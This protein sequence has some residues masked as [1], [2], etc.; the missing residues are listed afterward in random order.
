MLSEHQCSLIESGLTTNVEP[1]KV[2]AYLCLHM[3]LMLGEV[4]ALR[5]QDV[6][7]ES[8]SVNVVNTIGR[9]DGD[10]GKES[11]FTSAAYPRLLPM[12]PHVYRYLVKHSDLYTSD[13]C[14]IMNGST[15]VPFFHQMQNLLTSISTKYAVGETVSAM[16]LRNAFIRRCIRSNVDLFSICA[17]IGVKQPNVIVR[18]FD[19]Y[20]TPNLKSVSAIE[21]YV[22]ASGQIE[23]DDTDLINEPKRMNLLIL[24]AGSQGPVVK[25]IA[26][27]L[28]VFNEIAFLDDNPYNDLA[29]GP[30]SNYRYLVN[31]FPIAIPSF[32]DS[33][34][35]EK[36]FK[37]LQDAGYIIPT[38]LHPSATVSPT[39]KIDFGVVAEARSTISANTVIGHGAIV[40]SGAVVE[41]GARVG[42][43]VHIGSSVTISKGVTI[44]DYM[45]VDSG[46][47]VRDKIDE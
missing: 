32:G 34:L 27:A 5:W 46:R 9:V 31:R 36:W 42:R 15:D 3:G 23:Y 28:D 33:Y 4:A 16:D 25:E 44:P 21:R 38:L 18:R 6:D 8:S 29:M 24:G 10:V 43:F 17:Y 2:A 45:R 37:C 11:V 47:T 1:R 30:L 14:F 35:R 40:S 19:E 26:M 7:L 12:P 39:A 22:K 13:D 41:S 20:F